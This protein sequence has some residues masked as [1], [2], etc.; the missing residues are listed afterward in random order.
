MLAKGFLTKYRTQGR[1]IMSILL[2]KLT[3]PNLTNLQS[4]IR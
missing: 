1:L 2:Q 3:N 4:F